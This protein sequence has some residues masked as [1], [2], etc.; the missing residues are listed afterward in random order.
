ML[1]F[2]LRLA[3]ALLVGFAFVAPARAQLEMSTRAEVG[4]ETR[5]FYPDGR[6]ASQEY[7]LAA[8]ARLEVDVE[9]SW[10]KSKARTFV[11]MDPSDNARSRL[12]GEELWVEGAYERFRLRAGLQM[13]AWTATEAFHPSDVVNSRYF[14]S[15]LENPEKL[16]EPMLL[17][18]LRLWR[19]ANLE[20]MYMP[21]FMRPVYPSA[22]SR[23]N[24]FTPGVPP[25]KSWRQLD[26]DG[27]SSHSVFTQQWGVRYTQTIGG[28]D[29]G[30]QVLQ[31][32]ERQFPLFL[33]D[34]EG[35]PTRIVFQPVLHA[36][37][38]YLHALGPFVL[39]AEGAYRR[40]Q[41]HRAGGQ[42]LPERDFAIAAFGL[43]YGLSHDNGSDS[44]FLLEAQGV[45]FI[46]DDA[47]LFR[48][49]FEH[50]VMVGYRLSVNDE[51]SKALLLTA[52]VDLYYPEQFF[53]NAIY[54]Q[55]LTDRWSCEGGLRI[56]RFPPP[57]DRA[58]TRFEWLNNAHQLFVNLK[59]YF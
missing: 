4:A 35:R 5:L 54:T 19:G 37:F 24:F 6:A 47:K 42:P 23:Y 50:D 34:D 57:G 10:F 52:I 12:I 18:Q 9:R 39:K 36:G 25:P 3:G 27:E 1:R 8:V 20:L 45:W 14:D 2:D 43:E 59:A 33:F 49:L 26:R 29:L 21:I 11:R 22:R 53:I 38:T 13:L 30:L 48:P 7:N 28:A 51:Q 44:T 32:L 40:Y 16:G 46:G 15:S 31:Q 55:R 17:G 41:P 56:A 58:P